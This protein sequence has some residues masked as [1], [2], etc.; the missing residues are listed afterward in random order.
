MLQV[1]VVSQLFGVFAF[2][3]N[4]YFVFIQLTSIR[5][6]QCYLVIGGNP[7]SELSSGDVEKIGSTLL[8]FEYVTARRLGI[9]AG[10]IFICP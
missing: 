2:L 6:L 9:E 10:A 8:T 3:R 7:T 5:S 1:M 4:G